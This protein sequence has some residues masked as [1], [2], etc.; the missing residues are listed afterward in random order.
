VDA[1]A[2]RAYEFFDSDRKGRRCLWLLRQSIYTRLGRY[3][4][5]NYAEWLSQESAANSATS[6]VLVWNLLLYAA[7]RMEMPS[8]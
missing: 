2:R 1:P 6:A 7:I 4:D 3:E 5:V 8:N